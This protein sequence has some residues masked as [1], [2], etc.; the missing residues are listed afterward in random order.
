MT[1]QHTPGMYEVICYRG[2]DPV[3]GRPVIVYRDPQAPAWIEE[4]TL[5][6]ILKR[7]DTF[8]SLL[9][10]CEAALFFV[11]FDAGQD[12]DG[13]DEIRAKLEAAISRAKGEA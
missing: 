1:A 13:V 7:N 2:G 9:A 11:N 12:S 3:M 10:A 8:D 5:R 4:E 6:D